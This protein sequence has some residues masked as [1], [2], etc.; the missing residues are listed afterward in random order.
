MVA[1][2]DDSTH[3]LALS[4]RLDPEDTGC[5]YE[6]YVSG[7]FHFPGRINSALRGFARRIHEMGGATVHL[8]RLEGEDQIELGVRRMGT[9]GTFLFDNAE[10][11]YYVAAIHDPVTGWEI[12]EVSFTLIEGDAVHIVGVLR[13]RSVSWR[14][15]YD[16]TNPTLFN[17]AQAEIASRIAK[18]AG[19]SKKTVVKLR[20][21]GFA[22]AVIIDELSVDP[23]LI[24]MRYSDGFAPK[25]ETAN[26][27]SIQP[28]EGD[29]SGDTADTDP[30]APF[31]QGD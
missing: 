21:D 1:H 2:I 30:L 16:P 11:G 7:S 4:Y 20:E 6:S 3:I 18:G 19:V 25:K 8:R 14:I 9:E 15:T 29:A 28:F 22:W 26:A 23:R 10:P 13:R 12:S 24:G 27:L 31:A 5:H 17:E